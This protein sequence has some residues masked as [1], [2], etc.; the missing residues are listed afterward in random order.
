MVFTCFISVPSFICD[1]LLLGFRFSGKC[2]SS[3]TLF[4]NW[5]S[6]CKDE[7][8]DDG[9][10]YR[11][12][13]HRFL[14]VLRKCVLH[15]RRFHLI[16]T[17]PFSNNFYVNV[18]WKYQQNELRTYSAVRNKNLRTKNCLYYLFSVAWWKDRRTNNNWHTR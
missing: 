15:E 11:K 6:S 10:K 2:I 7:D 13:T 12:A 9:K 18:F 3:S 16:S 17:E 14:A 1:I 5:K 4:N 8:G